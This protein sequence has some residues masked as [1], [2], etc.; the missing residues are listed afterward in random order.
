MSEICK[1]LH[2]HLEQLPLIRFPFD[3]N[4]LPENGIYFMYEEGETLCKNENKL[5][6]VR[7]GTHNKD[8]NFRDRIAEHYLF[9]ESKMNFDQ[10]KP[11]PH[12]RSILRKHIGSALVNKRCDPYLSIWEEIDFTFREMREKFGHQ[13]DIPK[14]KTLEYEITERI[15]L[16]LFFRFII[17]NDKAIRKELEK[18]FIGTIAYC[19]ICKPTN[20]WLGNFSPKNKIK[21]SGLWQVQHLKANGIT[22]IT[23]VIIIEAI[24]DTKKWLLDNERTI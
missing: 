10:N 18:A 23:K 11:A 4:Q 22:E 16:Q 9:D 7:I 3:L 1:W 6:I 14:E 13:R 15:R 21:E 12:E 2:E 8:G 17:I 19:S 5:R 20:H 24:K